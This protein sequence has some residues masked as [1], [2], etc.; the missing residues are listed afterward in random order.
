[1]IKKF[2]KNGSKRSTVIFI[3]KKTVLFNAESQKSGRRELAGS[4]FCRP[5]LL[6]SQETTT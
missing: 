2:K 1:L 5:E 4:G 3:I 6:L